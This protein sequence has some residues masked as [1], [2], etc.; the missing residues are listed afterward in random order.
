MWL[1]ILGLRRFY[2]QLASI[3]PTAVI[4]IAYYFKLFLNF[5]NGYI[6]VMRDE[7]RK[8]YQIR[9]KF[10][11]YCIQILIYG[12]ILDFISIFF[13]QIMP[14]YSDFISISVIILVCI[15]FCTGLAFILLTVSIVVQELKY[16][17]DN[18]EVNSSVDNLDI[19]SAH[20]KLQKVVQISKFCYIF[21]VPPNLLF[22]FWY[23]LRRKYTYV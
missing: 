9:K 22:P 16:Y 13:G 3:V 15:M 4:G 14:K 19:I 2:S 5:L 7:V 1:E 21:C 23:F 8:Q 10:S 6:R 17:I 20:W 11:D 18:L 12:S